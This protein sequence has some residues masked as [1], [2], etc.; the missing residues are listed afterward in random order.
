MAD[1]RAGI[2]TSNLLLELK[3]EVLVSSDTS[4]IC[5][6][7][8]KERQVRLSL[9]AL[10]QFYRLHRS[11]DQSG[12]AFSQLKNEQGRQAIRDEVTEI[13]RQMATFHSHIN[14]W[15]E[16]KRTSKRF[17]SVAGCISPR[18]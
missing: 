3:A 10:V 5:V 4:T 16:T 17:L 1:V 12:F 15:L 13:R 9:E 6:S 7:H 11:D 14:I 8:Q 18:K 2:S